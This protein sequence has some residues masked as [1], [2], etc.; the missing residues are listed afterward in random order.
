MIQGKREWG[1]N[2]EPLILDIIGTERALIQKQSVH[3]SIT[4]FVKIEYLHI[5]LVLRTKLSIPVKF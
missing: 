2:F 1:H 4:I 3:F 5:R